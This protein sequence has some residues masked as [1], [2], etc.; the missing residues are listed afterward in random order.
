VNSNSL[1]EFT[2]GLKTLWTNLKKQLEL[3]GNCQNEIQFGQRLANACLSERRLL[4]GLAV[5]DR[6]TPGC[7][8]AL[9]DIPQI[10]WHPQY[11]ALLET[12]S[13]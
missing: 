8:H 4:E 3:E 2:D 7:F 9:A 11:E 6:F 12:S 10:G 13:K 1:V 5:P